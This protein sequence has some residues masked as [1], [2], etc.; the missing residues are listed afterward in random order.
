MAPRNS[1]RFPNDAAFHAEATALLRAARNSKVQLDG[2]RLFVTVDR[3]LCLRCEK[4]LPKVGMLL[5]NPTV[6][7]T[8]PK[9]TTSTMSNGAWEKK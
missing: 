4:V 8:D 3:E 2:K 5:G 1:G 9:G 7:F 6:T